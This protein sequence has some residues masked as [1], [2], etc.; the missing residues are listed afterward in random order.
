MNNPNSYLKHEKALKAN[1]INRAAALFPF[2]IGSS[3][4]TFLV[5]QNYW[6]WKRQVNVTMRIHVYDNLGK[7]LKFHEEVLNKNSYQII[8][9]KLLKSS[10]KK[11]EGM[12]EIEIISD[13]DKNIVF[14]FPAIMVFFTN[15]KGEFSGVHSAGRTLSEENNDILKFDETNFYCKLNEDFSPF[16]HLFTGVNSYIKN[17]NIK[18]LSIENHLIHE[19]V[20]DDIIGNYRSSVVYLKHHISNEMIDKLSTYSRFYIKISG[21][22]R[23]IYPRFIVGNFSLKNNMHYVTHS[24]RSVLENDFYTLDK[25]N[26]K[27]HISSISLMTP[28]NVCLN[29]SIYPTCGPSAIVKFE[30][31]KRDNN[32]I[33][34]Y[35]RKK[36][37]ESFDIGL[38]NGSVISEFLN[39]NQSVGYLTVKGENVPSRINCGLEFFDENSHHPTDIALQFRLVHT[40]KKYNFW[41]HFSNINDFRTYLLISNFLASLNNEKCYLKLYIGDEEDYIKCFDYFVNSG[42]CLTIDL[43]KEFSSVLNKTNKQKMFLP[44]RIEVLEGEIQDIYI[45][46]HN[47]STGAIFGDHSF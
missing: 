45:L 42:D 39:P 4:D 10:Q 31:F 3:S 46:S 21:K 6:Q 15:G 11:I 8:V 40:S 22:V 7:K 29:S 18:I 14:P 28:P 43:N 9:S 27:T 25:I 13:K 35:N 33:N 32:K 16:V 23:G 47:K 19:F 41:G 5:F 38:K 12:I 24:F 1:Q 17:I 37:Q 36:E 30:K 34:L 20:L 44:W 2:W 26:D